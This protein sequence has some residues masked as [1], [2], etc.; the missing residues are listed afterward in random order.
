ML[1]LGSGRVSP[2]GKR[3]IRLSQW[4]ISESH[5]TEVRTH[6]KPAGNPDPKIKTGS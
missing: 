6:E 5:L 2:D 3:D 4:R 1:E